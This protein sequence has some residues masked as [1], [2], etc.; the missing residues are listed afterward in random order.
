MT[1]TITAYGVGLFIH[2]LAVVVALGVTFGYGVFMAHAQKN[3]PEALPAVIRAV[4]FCNRVLVTPGLVV[5]LFAGIY[6][7]SKGNI[8]A[9]ESWIS[10]GFIAIIALFG[11]VH[12]FFMPNERRAAEIADR[13][14]QAGGELSPEFEAISKR[15]ALGGQIAGLIIAVTIFFMAVKP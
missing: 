12:G 3:A 6:L 14:L 11:M 1:A 9:S 8:D 13:D 15:L 4:T 10:V 7:M 2:I 5:V